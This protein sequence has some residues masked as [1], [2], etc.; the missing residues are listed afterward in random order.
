MIPPLGVVLDIVDASDEASVEW[1]FSF[2]PPLGVML[3]IVDADEEGCFVDT[4][5]T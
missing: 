1:V 5:G 4:V 2:V 3:D